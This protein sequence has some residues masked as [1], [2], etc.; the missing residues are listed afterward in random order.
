[1]A[2]TIIKPRIRGFICTTAH[3]AGCTSNVN[4]QIKIATSEQKDI[5]VPFRVLVIGSSTGYG[6]AA[7]IAAG[8]MYRRVDHH[9]I[10]F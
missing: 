10:V 6:L 4:D 9:A 7:R 8:A 2:L 5:K 3:P 1:M